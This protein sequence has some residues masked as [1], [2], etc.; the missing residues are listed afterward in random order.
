MN[1]KAAAVAACSAAIA[2]VITGIL[3]AS[4]PQGR[5]AELRAKAAQSVGTSPENLSKTAGLVDSIRKNDGAVSDADWEHLV[6]QVESDNKA[7]RSMALTAMA[8]MDPESRHKDDALAYARG[9]LAEGHADGTIPAI[10][11]LRKFGDP[12]W[13]TH[14]EALAKSPNPSTAEAAQNVLDKS[15]E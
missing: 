13:R 4:Q 6:S 10:L 9:F 12:A 3:F 8:Q 1:K 15:A 2:A 11:V 7:L 5:E 14:A